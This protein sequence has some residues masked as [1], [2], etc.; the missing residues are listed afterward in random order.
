MGRRDLKA[1][2]NRRTHPNSGRES[3]SLYRRVELINQRNLQ[4]PQ[5]EQTD[6]AD[7][8]SIQEKIK[9]TAGDHETN[10]NGKR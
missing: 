6:V 1:D 10:S 5:K 8:Q 4:F 9:G 2:I 7:E 3:L